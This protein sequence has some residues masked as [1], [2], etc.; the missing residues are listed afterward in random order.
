MTEKRLFNL[1][2]WL[3]DKSQKVVTSSD[4]PVTILKWNNDLY[5]QSVL[6]PIIAVVDRG[7]SFNPAYLFNADGVASGSDDYRLYF[8]ATEDET[9]SDFELKVQACMLQVKSGVIVDPGTEYDKVKE[10]ADIL[11]RMYEKEYLPKWKRMPLGPVAYAPDY[12]GIS[13]VQTSSVGSLSTGV[14]S[15]QK[16]DYYLPLFD[17][18]NFPKES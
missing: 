16:G 10:W 14:Q 15:V 1:D 7:T 6:Y 11:K 13:L 18:E 8:A 5:L 2:E 17:I 4:E 9:L 3:K 12:V